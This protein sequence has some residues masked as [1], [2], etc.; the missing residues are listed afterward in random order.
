[1]PPGVK[2]PVQRV[3]QGTRPTSDGC[4]SACRGAQG[5]IGSFDEDWRR[6]E[7][8]DAAYALGKSGA[9][10][11][12]QSLWGNRCEAQTLRAGWPVIMI[13]RDTKYGSIESKRT[14][15]QIDISNAKNTGVSWPVH[16]DPL[17]SVLSG[18]DS[19][20][21]AEATLVMNGWPG[22]ICSSVQPSTPVSS[23]LQL[24]F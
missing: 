11:T 6:A 2:S 1:M 21:Q 10:H 12:G 19:S 4:R 15:V 14:I 8:S 5:R 7:I 13:V 24:Q 3:F 18:R 9:T 22:V 23:P 16:T 17:R 20:L